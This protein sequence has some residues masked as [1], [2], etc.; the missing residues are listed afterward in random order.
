MTPLLLPEPPTI[1][2]AQIRNV[3]KKWLKVSDE[4]ALN[5]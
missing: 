5:A 4:R 2:M 1:N 3:E